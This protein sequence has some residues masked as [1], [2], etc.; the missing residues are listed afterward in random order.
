MYVTGSNIPAVTLA[1]HERFKRE[2][3]AVVPR[4]SLSNCMDAVGAFPTIGDHL[5]MLAIMKGCWKLA[6]AQVLAQA[7]EGNRNNTAWTVVASAAARGIPVDVVWELFRR[8]FKGWGGFSE[9]DLESAIEH[10]PVPL[11][12]R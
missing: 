5:R 9:Q 1:Q 10:E 4:W 12:Q 11:P 3:F 8:H 7:L 6:A 2:L